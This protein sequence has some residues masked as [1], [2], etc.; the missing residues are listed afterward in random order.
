[1]FLL[2]ADT[3]ITNLTVPL[4]EFMTPQSHVVIS[5]E[6]GAPLLSG[7]VM[8]R[9]SKEGRDFLAKWKGKSQSWSL[10]FDNGGMLQSILE[11]IAT[12]DEARNCGRVGSLN[13]YVE[14]N[15]CFFNLLEKRT[16]PFGAR[17]S[18]VFR[19][20][21]PSI[22]WSRFSEEDMSMRRG[23]EYAQLFQQ[24]SYRSW[25]KGDFLVHAKYE[26]LPSRFVTLS[27]DD[28]NSVS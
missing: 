12:P 16:G 1:M 26:S 23:P 27:S 24:Q 14:Y 3:Y 11:T 9:N 19:F 25:K 10:D 4:T 21:P 13:D 20:L 15:R 17:V 22:S 6:D 18:S 28:K 8:I 7:M 5:D 2:D